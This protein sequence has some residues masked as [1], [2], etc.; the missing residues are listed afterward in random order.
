[1]I[2]N[3]FEKLILIR[4]RKETPSCK[5]SRGGYTIIEL[6]VVLAIL[7]ILAGVSV[8]NISKWLKLAK[9][10]ETKSVVNSALAECIQTFR[11]GTIPKDATPPDRIISNERLEPSGYKIKTSDNTCASY[12]VTPKSDKE[13]ILFELGFKIS[14]AL[15]F[16]LIIVA[17][18][19]KGF[20]SLLIRESIIFG[21]I[22]GS[23]P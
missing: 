5:N 11:D 16:L 4:I 15:K 14:A 21:S 23:S 1:M 3:Q 9:I 22:I 17:N 12:L 13:D 18:S 6:S 2:K 19:T 20:S 10:D 7:A 8:P